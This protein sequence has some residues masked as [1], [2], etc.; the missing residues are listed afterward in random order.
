LN[1]PFPKL[2][3]PCNIRP[4][5][6]QGVNMRRQTLA[7]FLQF[8]QRPGGKIGPADVQKILSQKPKSIAKEAAD[9]EDTCTVP[10]TEKFSQKTATAVT[11]GQLR[12]TESQLTEYNKAQPAILQVSGLPVTA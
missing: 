9:G 5:P 4:L 6:V 3:P 2:S 10:T 8:V 1:K 12:Y 7:D 11:V